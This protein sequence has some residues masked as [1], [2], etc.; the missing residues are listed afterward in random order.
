M[1]TKTKNIFKCSKEIKWQLLDISLQA[2]DWPQKME[3]SLAQ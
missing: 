2:L 1:F 3:A